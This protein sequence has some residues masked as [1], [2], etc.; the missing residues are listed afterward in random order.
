M[1]G[2]LKMSGIRTLP[3]GTHIGTKWTIS[4]TVNSGGSRIVYLGKERSLLRSKVAIV[5]SDGSLEQGKLLKQESDV[6]QTI[7]F[8]RAKKLFRPM[9]YGSFPRYKGSFAL[10]CRTALV[11]GQLGDNLYTALEKTPNNKMPF[12]EVSKIAVDVIH[13][14]KVIHYFGYVHRDIKP[15]NLLIGSGP[16][17]W[18][19][20]RRRKRPIDLIGFR[21]TVKYR[22]GG[23][24]KENTVDGRPTTLVGTSMYAPMAS[25]EL[26]NQKPRDDIESLMYV[27]AF[28]CS[29]ELPW[30]H[31]GDLETTDA[32]NEI[33]CMKRKS[34]ESGS[35][36]HLFPQNFLSALKMVTRLGPDDL[37][38]YD[39]LINEL[40][41]PVLEL[42]SLSY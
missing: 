37:P 16:T 4:G 30:C 40:Q 21:L 29:G 15:Q 13:S 32:Y 36:F 31:Y 23:Y 20:L 14:L 11:L 28:L 35:L 1:F 2:S 41:A 27:M 10:G 17:I 24:E 42:Q 33:Q 9:K 26:H 3:I 18:S 6:Y 25:H 34:L 38:D 19:L 7:E 12:A 39:R 5:V 22:C 8:Q